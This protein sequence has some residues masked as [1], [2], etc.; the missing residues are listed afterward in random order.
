MQLLSHS[1]HASVQQGYGFELCAIPIHLFYLG[2][3]VAAAGGKATD[4]KIPV[5]CV[6]GN[7]MFTIAL[8][9]APIGSIHQERA[10]FS[11]ALTLSPCELIQEMSWKRTDHQPQLAPSRGLG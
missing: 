7:C 6:D 10:S 4:W 5:C 11:W 2:T 8:V 3:T 1:F 9:L